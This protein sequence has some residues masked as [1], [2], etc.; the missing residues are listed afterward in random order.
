VDNIK[1]R[2]LGWVDHKEWKINDPPPKNK[3]LNGIFHN[4]RPVEKLRT[5]VGVIQRDTPQIS[6]IRGWR[7]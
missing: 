7:R 2:R 5:R 1:I 3:V 6:G 4:T